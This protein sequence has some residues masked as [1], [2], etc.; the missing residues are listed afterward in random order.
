M[1]SAGGSDSAA[2]TA[3]AGDAPAEVSPPLSFSPSAASEM[4]ATVEKY[5][6]SLESGSRAFALAKHSDVVSASDIQLA[7]SS[8]VVK[9]ERGKIQ[10]IRDISVLVMGLGLGEL[11]IMVLSSTYTVRDLVLMFIPLL[12]GAVIYAFCWGS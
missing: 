8:L 2:I 10:R 12:V 9:Q 3:Q 6:L 11:A 5:R 1:T 4:A 7:A